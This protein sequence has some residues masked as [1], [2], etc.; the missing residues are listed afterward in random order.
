M[1]NFGESLIIKINADSI[2]KWDA[3][4]DSAFFMICFHERPLEQK[5]LENLK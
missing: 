4:K 5:I 2:F 3:L 1:T